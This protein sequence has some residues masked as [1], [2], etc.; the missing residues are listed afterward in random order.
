M[1]GFDR[2]G[3]GIADSENIER[4]SALGSSSSKW[5]VRSSFIGPQGIRSGWSTLIFIVILMIGV[6]ATRVP[7]NYL[8]HSMKHNP[9]L[10]ATSAS[11]EARY[12]P[13]PYPTNQVAPKT[14]CSD[15]RLIRRCRDVA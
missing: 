8:L 4:E 9:R 3:E 12:A 14:T 5:T 15:I 6:L 2:Q 10:E 13:L 11:F 7:V 1:N